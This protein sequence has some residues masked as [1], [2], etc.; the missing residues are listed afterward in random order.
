LLSLYGVTNSALLLETGL[1]PD[2]LLPP[3]YS[4]HYSL[5]SSLMTHL[6]I[7]H[8][9]THDLQPNSDLPT[10]DFSP[11]SATLTHLSIATKDP[12]NSGS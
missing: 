4:L 5:Q 8:D 11:C 7:K 12:I 9:P 6:A 2:T 10:L 3:P 1:F